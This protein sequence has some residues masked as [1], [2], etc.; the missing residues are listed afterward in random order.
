[1]SINVQ[2]IDDIEEKMLSFYFAGNPEIQLLPKE[3][4]KYLYAIDIKKIT[5]KTLEEVYELM[6]KSKWDI[7]KVIEKLKSG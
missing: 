4:M 2:L 5:S 1:M 7:K 3:L 6:K